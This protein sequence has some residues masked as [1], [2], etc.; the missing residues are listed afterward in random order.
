MLKNSRKKHIWFH[1]GGAIIFAG[2]ILGVA[3]QDFN[4]APEIEAMVSL[5]HHKIPF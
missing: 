3:W 2:A 1:A 4:S 5:V